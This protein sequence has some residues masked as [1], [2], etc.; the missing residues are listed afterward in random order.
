MLDKSDQVSQALGHDMWTT[1]QEAAHIVCWLHLSASTI[2]SRLSAHWYCGA[3]SKRRKR[4]RGGLGPGFTTWTALN[5]P[6]WNRNGMGLVATNMITS[7]GLEPMKLFQIDPK[8]SQGHL[9][10]I[11]RSSHITIYCFVSLQFDQLKSCRRL[12]WWLG[13]NSELVGGLGHFETSGEFAAV[14]H[15][16]LKGHNHQ[17][18]YIS[19][20]VIGKLTFDGFNLILHHRYLWLLTMIMV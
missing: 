4:R 20:G 17:Q 19:C 7:D 10:N 3:V 13:S 8:D 14:N 9:Q 11:Y 2:P 1:I 6:E 16:V 18:R 12:P 5:E 15:R